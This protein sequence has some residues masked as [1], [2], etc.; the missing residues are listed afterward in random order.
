MTHFSRLYSLISYW[1]YGSLW[2]SVAIGS[3]FFNNAD[4]ILWMDLVGRVVSCNSSSQSMPDMTF[5]VEVWKILKTN[6][7]G[8]YLQF[9]ENYRPEKLYVVA[10]KIKA[11]ITIE[12]WNILLLISNLYVQARISVP[13]ISYAFSLLWHGGIW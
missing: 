3:P 2:L 5:R 6:L 10:C 1:K 9:L 7:S 4:F 12:N 8:E 13:R 11:N